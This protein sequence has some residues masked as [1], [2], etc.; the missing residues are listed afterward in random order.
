V[1]G[2]ASPAIQNPQS[3][4]RFLQRVAVWT[5]MTLAVLC[6]LAVGGWFG[7]RWWVKRCLAYSVAGYYSP[8]GERLRS[9]PDFLVCPVLIDYIRTCNN[10]NYFNMALGLLQDR[11]LG[12]QAIPRPCPPEFVPPKVS[13]G[14]RQWV[15]RLPRKMLEDLYIANHEGPHDSGWA[16]VWCG[17][18][19]LIWTFEPLDARWHQ[20]YSRE[21][22]EAAATRLAMR[23]YE[24]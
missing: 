3:Q 1:P 5:A 21:E 4:S 11:A 17:G 12:G 10:E 7:G 22:R 24:W 19:E 8:E 15:S 16:P 18:P 20:T 13:P 14:M 9:L 2:A 23:N 6:L